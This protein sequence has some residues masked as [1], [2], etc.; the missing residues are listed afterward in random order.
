MH[1]EFPSINGQVLRVTLYATEYDR[2]HVLQRL[3]VLPYPD[4][5]LRKMHYVIEVPIAPRKL[6]LLVSPKFGGGP[7]LISL[8][9]RVSSAM[10]QSTAKIEQLAGKLRFPPRGRPL[11]LI[12]FGKSPRGAIRKDYDNATKR[13]VD[14]GVPITL[15]NRWR[16]ISLVVFSH[17]SRPYEIPLVKK[18]SILQKR[19]LGIC[20]D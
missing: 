15:S 7:F 10:F 6:G 14:R 3:G 1:I 20:L 8:S 16:T 18:T 4:P 5:C 17:L 11:H 13:I 19:P 12:D 2:A 9:R